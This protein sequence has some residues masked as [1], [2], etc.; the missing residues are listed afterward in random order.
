MER[1]LLPSHPNTCNTISQPRP[2][3]IY[4]YPF[5]AFT[6]AQHT[7]LQHFHPEIEFYSQANV[8]MWFAFFIV[9]FK[10][11]AGTRGD[12]WVAANQCAGGS[13]ACLQALNQPNLIIDEKTCFGLIAN[14]CY[15]LAMDNNLGQLYVSWKDGDFYR[16][17]RV[18]SFLL[19]DTEH[20]E[21]LSRCVDSI[22]EWGEIR[23][24]D[25]HTAVNNIKAT[26]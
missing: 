8:D 20:L 13:A 23:R 16:I 6:Q 10:A 1:H 7:I 26:Q 9:E 4:G 12:L 5:K 21:R 25:I 24:W 18:A 19:S 3:L 17:Q 2:D 22:L 14:F 11:A 15:S